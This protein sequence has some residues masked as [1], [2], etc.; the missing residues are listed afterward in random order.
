MHPLI[1]QAIACR[2]L[3]AFDYQGHHRVVEPYCHGTGRAGQDFLRA[4]QISG[5]SASGPLGWK[6]FDLAHVSNLRVL[7]KQFAGRADYRA[8]DKA[9]HPLHCRV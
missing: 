7:E 1:C 5:T 8:E 4:F 3:L 6:L 2:R 9:M